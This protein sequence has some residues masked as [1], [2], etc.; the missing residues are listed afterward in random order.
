MKQLSE[1][2]NDINDNDNNNSS[3]NN[4][5]TSTNGGSSLRCYL[6]KLSW[7]LFNVDKLEI[8]KQLT[9]IEYKLLKQIKV[10]IYLSQLN[11]LQQ[12]SN[13][14]TDLLLLLLLCHYLMY[15]IHLFREKISG[16][17][18]IQTKEMILSRLVLPGSM[19]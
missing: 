14:W 12:S 6:R 10:L 5:N 13:A 4:N 9:L 8:A 18:V 11:G 19:P 7:V 1:N 3:N 2:Q 15:I 17:L 16:V